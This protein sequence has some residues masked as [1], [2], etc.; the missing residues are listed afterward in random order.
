LLHRRSESVPILG[1]PP[2]SLDE[3][4]SEGSSWYNGLE[5]SLTKR[6]SHGLQFLASYTFSKTLDT[7][8]ADVNG[9]SAGT[10]LTL[11]D[12]NSPG[13]RWGRTSF[14]RPQRFILSGTWT[15]PSP[16]HGV[17]GAL[18]GGW[19]LAAIVTIQSG[20]ALTIAYAN[21]S[22]TFGISEDRAQLSG[23]CAKSQI[24]ISGSVQSK[25]NNYFDKA[26]FTTP[27]I[28]GADGKGTAFGDSATGIVDGPGQANIDLSISKNIPLRWPQQGSNLQFRAEFFNASNHPQF[29]NPDNNFS[30]ETFG[31]ISSTSVNPR[32]GQLALKLS[33]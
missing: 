3:V 25:L 20:S 13:H 23:S 2:D 1:I 31:V 11:G 19:D 5:V 12:Q 29:S 28:I 17:K 26:C 21:A 27:P 22:N 15:S 16:S 14:D 30:S 24:V 10:V 7:D 9:T 8:G 6:L 18:L 33:F 4:E 32:V